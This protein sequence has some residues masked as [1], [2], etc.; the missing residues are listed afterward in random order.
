MGIIGSPCFSMGYLLKERKHPL[1]VLSLHNN[2][3]KWGITKQE[4]L[5][6]A[7]CSWQGEQK[8]LDPQIHEFSLKISSILLFVSAVLNVTVPG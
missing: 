6:E 3:L 4:N 5:A 8:H 2:S 7:Q 1:G